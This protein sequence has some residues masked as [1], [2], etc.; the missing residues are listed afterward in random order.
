MKHQNWFDAEKQRR[1]ARGPKPNGTEPRAWLIIGG[2]NISRRKH[3]K[4]SIS[5]RSDECGA[6]ARIASIIWLPQDVCRSRHSET[7]G[8]RTRHE[9]SHDGICMRQKEAASTSRE[10]EGERGN[11]SQG[12]AQF[13][14]IKRWQARVGT[15]SSAQP[16]AITGHN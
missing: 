5:Y 7:H 16:Q 8:R 12:G 10:G 13:V 2:Q 1:R 15:A 4:H 9:A 3:G 6:S 11:Q 14:P